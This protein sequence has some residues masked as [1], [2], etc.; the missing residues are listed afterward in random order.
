MPLLLRGFADHFDRAFLADD[1]VY[2]PFGNLDLG[3]RPE[4][5]LVDPRVYRR[6][7]FRCPR[8]LHHSSDRPL[9][10]V[11]FEY[12][13]LLLKHFDLGG[14]AEIAILFFFQAEDGI[15][16]FPERERSSSKFRIGS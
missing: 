10:W 11:A 16:D 15:R 4:L 1:L 14:G 7:L 12:T 2:E 9:V 13:I 3:R 6:E 8:S 5:H